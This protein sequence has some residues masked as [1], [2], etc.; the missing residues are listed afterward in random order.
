M[1]ISVSRS[2]SA[3]ILSRLDTLAHLSESDDGLT[4]QYLSVEHREANELVGSWMR[5]AGMRV[6]QDAIGNIIGRYEGEH[7]GAPSVRR[8][9]SISILILDT[10]T[11]TDT[12]W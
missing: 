8:Y 9:M 4:R 3:A 1:N 12:A 11:H 7:E 10:H 6:Y 5:E 2:T